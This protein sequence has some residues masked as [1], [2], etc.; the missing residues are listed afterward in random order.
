MRARDCSPGYREEFFS[1]T[2]H[3]LI[4]CGESSR[5]RAGSRRIGAEGSRPFAMPRR[6]RLATCRLLV[7]PL[8]PLTLICAPCGGRACESPQ[9][10]RSCHLQNRSSRKSPTGAFRWGCDEGSRCEL[11]YQK[12]G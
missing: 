5:R 12:Q 4:R 1:E 10:N 11:L 7:K 8:A 9:N 3:I 6:R 2:E